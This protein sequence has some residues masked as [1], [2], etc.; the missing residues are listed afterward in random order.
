MTVRQT[1]NGVIDQESLVLNKECIFLSGDRC[2]LS[3]WVLQLL[4]EVVAK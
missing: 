4:L 1:P 3:R 2:G